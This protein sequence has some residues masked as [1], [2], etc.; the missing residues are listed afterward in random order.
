[1]N[2]STTDS[3]DGV[4]NCECEKER[5]RS[6]K[7]NF[8]GET[9][10]SLSIQPC[11]R[12]LGVFTLRIDRGHDIVDSV[13]GMTLKKKTRVRGQRPWN[14]PDPAAQSIRVH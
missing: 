10:P 9:E 6:V 2:H 4:S 12:S 13:H 8:D 11:L 5:E 1:M 7:T 14:D 3:S